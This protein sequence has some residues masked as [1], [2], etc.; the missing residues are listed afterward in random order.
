MRR[1]FIRAGL[2]LAMAA[3]AVAPY[4]ASAAPTPLLEVRNRTNFILRFTYATADMT[5]PL[6]TAVFPGK[7]WTFS[8]PGV[9]FFD[10]YLDEGGGK[11]LTLQRHGILLKPE[12]KMGILIA[13][14]D[15]NMNFGKGDYRWYVYYPLG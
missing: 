10:G 13:T 2:V 14:W 3:L 9:W 11:K 5:T 12:G 6:Q 15:Q 1:I 4:C 7:T 8:L